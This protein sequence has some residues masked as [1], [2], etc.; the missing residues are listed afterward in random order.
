MDTYCYGGYWNNDNNCGGM[1]KI[2]SLLS[3]I[4]IAVYMLMACT[5]K[6][7]RVVY[8][9]SRTTAFT[10][11]TIAKDT[12]ETH[13]PGMKIADKP[14]VTETRGSRAVRFVAWLCLIIGLV[15][16]LG[17]C[18]CEVLQTDTYIPD[19]LFCGLTMCFIVFSLLGTLLFTVACK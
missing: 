16:L 8:G 1:R 18:I 6:S 3:I 19:E 5:T 11:A 4:I 13:C 10:T 9:G 2:F 7:N 12:V 17:L 15:S 14:A